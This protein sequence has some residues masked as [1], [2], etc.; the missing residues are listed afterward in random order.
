VLDAARL[1]EDGGEGD[2]DAT[3]HGNG[4][5][6]EERKRTLFDS[7]NP[8]IAPGTCIASPL[9]YSTSGLP[10][11]ALYRYAENAPG[12]TETNPKVDSRDLSR[13]LEILYSKSR[14][15]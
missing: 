6:K 13:M 11:T 15:G 9:K 7:D 2:A 3:N 12:R 10:E 1:Q 4:E 8:T 14:K 5:R